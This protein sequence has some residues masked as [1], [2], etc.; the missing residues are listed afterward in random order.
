MLVVGLIFLALADIALALSANLF[1]V[2]VGIILWGLYLA[3]TQ[4]VLSAMIA[5][6]APAELRGTA[7]GVFNFATGLALLAAS[8]AA[9]ALWDAYGPTATFLAGAALAGLALI[10]LMIVRRRIGP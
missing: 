10:G 9:G 8:A 4:G 5:D 2:A 6:S 3:F 7:F 1:G